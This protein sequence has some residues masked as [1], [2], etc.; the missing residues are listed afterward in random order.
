MSEARS[1]KSLSA[2]VLSRVEHPSGTGRNGEPDQRNTGTPARSI[3]PGRCPREKPALER[4]CSSVP[5]MEG[6]TA[7]QRNALP[8][9]WPERLRGAR[10]WADLTAICD[11]GQQAFVDGE[12]PGPVVERIGRQCLILSRRLP[13]VLP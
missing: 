5:G 6:G 13:E 9:P 1:L 10:S 3:V 12:L 2:E 11:D 7:E 4:Q 8:A